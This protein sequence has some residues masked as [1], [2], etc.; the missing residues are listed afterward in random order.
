[1]EKKTLSGMTLAE[2]ENVA[3]E[4]GMPK[5]AS[6]QIATWL[7]TKQIFSISEMS[8]ISKAFREKLEEHYVLGR[9]QPIKKV[10]SKDG[11][12]KYLFPTQSGHFVET[13]YIPTAERATLCVSSQVGCK[14][15]C[16]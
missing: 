7:Y 5:Y 12:V 6:K 16:S 8:N 15:G 2:L 9:K 1:M 10:K 3:Y 4:L 13:V 11:T 14:M